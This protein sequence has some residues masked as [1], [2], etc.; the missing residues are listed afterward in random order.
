V[1]VEQALIAHNPG[2]D[3]LSLRDVTYLRKY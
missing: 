1:S 2:I 3:P